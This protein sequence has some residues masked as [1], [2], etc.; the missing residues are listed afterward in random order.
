[1]KYSYRHILYM[2]VAVA[3]LSGCRGAKLSTADEQYARGEYHAAMLTYKKVYNK[4]TKRE[5]RP[6]RGTVAFRMGE[7][8][9]H[10][11][12]AANASGAYRNAIRYNYPDSMALLYLAQSQHMEGKYKDAVKNYEAFLEKQ[13]KSV[14]ARDGLRGSQNAARIK[15]T[16]TRYKVSPAKLFNS[17][18]ADFCPMFLDGSHDQLYFTSSTEKSKGAAKSEITGTKNSDIYVAKKNEKGVW[19]RPEPAEG[20]LNTDFDEGVTSFSPDGSTM[21]L[22]KARRE[23]NSATSVE[24]YTSQRSEA[25]WSAPVKLEITGDTLSAYG[26]PAVSPDGTWLYFSSD[27]PGGQGGKDLWRINL[28][29]R[30]G[31]LENL[32]DVIN[33]PGD[34]R[35]PYV[36]SDSVLYFASNGHAGLGGL[37][38]FKA[39]LTASGGWNIENMGWPMNSSYD[40]FGITFGEGESGFFSS[41]RNDARGYDHIYSFIKPELKI[42]ISGYVLDRDEEPVPNAVIRIVGD[43][44]SNQKAI[45]KSDGTFQ[46]NLQRGVKYVMMAGAK[47]YMNGKQEFV[48]DMAEEDAEYAVDFI[49]AAMTKPQVIENIFYDFDKASLRAESKAALDSMVTILKDNPQIVIEMASHTDRWGSNEY[50][51]KLSDRRAKSVV[52]YLIA[53]G[54]DASR[55]RPKGYGKTRPKTVTKR[56]ARLYPQFKEGDTLTEE[57]ISKLEKPDQDAADQINRRTEFQVISLQN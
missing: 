54:V 2:M 46:F 34:E 48:S 12:M 9:R 13:P 57:F 20:E 43:D 40:D 14:L 27:M 53:A 1:M 26:D 56:I 19:Q 47:G 31:S 17:R 30:V 49:L 10:L 36:R 32:G 8:Y 18:R 22:A 5:E 25:K 55:L 4:L 7:C 52:D 41:N 6:L 45:G 35:F 16:P 33:T 29:E 15:A 24:I 11:N 44:G 38:I 50:N 42:T 21:Y 39:T 51:L 28:K 23:L 3:M 37:D